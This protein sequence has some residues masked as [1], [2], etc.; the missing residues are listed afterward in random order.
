MLRLVVGFVLLAGFLV[1][2]PLAMPTAQA[3]SKLTVTPA[4]P[5][6]SEQFSVTGTIGGKAAR[7]VQ[8]QVRSGRNW[9]SLGQPGTTDASGRYSLTGTAT[10]KSL[11][12][13]VI[14]TPQPGLAK[15]ITQPGGSPPSASR[16][17]SR[18]PVAPTSIKP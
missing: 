13:R 2:S 16:G 8:L 17:S 1:S 9:K 6:R 7:P 12:V 11:T 14:A 4:K 10:G 5:V 15:V 18:W 3:A